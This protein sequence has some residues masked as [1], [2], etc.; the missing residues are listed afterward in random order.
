MLVREITT[1]PK[2]DARKVK[3]SYEDG[4]GRLHGRLC[5][6]GSS[7]IAIISPPNEG[8]A[9]PLAFPH[10]SGNIFCCMQKY[11]Y[12]CIRFELQY[13]TNLW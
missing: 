9:S 12:L 8:G 4:E 1:V 5:W 7:K 10:R 3:V 6:L 2:L 13:Y 11:V